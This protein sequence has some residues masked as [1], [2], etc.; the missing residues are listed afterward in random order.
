MSGEGATQVPFQA[1]VEL[2]R[3]FLAN[4]NTLVERIQ[5]LLN[6]QRKPVQYLQDRPFLARQFEDCFFTL[7]AVT[8][9]QSRLRG[10]LEQARSASGLGPRRMPELH[11]DLIAP[12]EMMIRGFYCWRQTRWPGRNGR[13]RYAQALFN[14]Y[15]IRCLELLSI[16]LWDLG[17]GAGD[18]L[19]QLQNVLDELWRGAPD[20]QPV[21]VRDAR[22]LIPL[23]QSPTTEELAA[24]FEVAERVVE[25]LAEGDSVEIQK[26]HV[27][28]IGGHLCSQ[29]R[30]YCIRDDLTVDE[31]SVVR[32]TRTS[33][34]L[35]FALLIQSLVS[36]LEA[37]DSA[38]RSGDGQRRLDLAGAI[39]QGI[40]ADPELFL[41]R[42]DLLGAYSLIEHLF[43]ATDKDGQAAYTPMGQRHIRLL[44]AYGTLINRHSKPLFD[45]CPNFRP[46]DGTCSPYGVI[47]GT[48][49]NLTEHMALKTLQPEAVT[50]FSL[51]DVFTDGDAGGEKLAWVNG[52]RKLPHVDPEMQ[53]RFAYP[54]RFAEEIFDRIEREFR[55]CVSGGEAGDTRLTGR[56]VLLPESGRGPEPSAS[57]IPDLPIRYIVSSDPRIVAAGKAESCDVTSLLHDRH[58]G[59]FALSY[60]TSSGWVAIKKDF[61]TEVLGA[62]HDAKIVGLPLAAAAV[63]RLMC[64]DM[65]IDRVTA[66]PTWGGTPSGSACHRA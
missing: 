55:R 40:S 35:D 5:N 32:R 44:Q 30:H 2:L 36:L 57:G 22:W 65:V 8:E 11:N 49:S 64:P 3:S 17:K 34:A 4:R 41:N 56:L 53:K 26:A 21:I 51:E 61:V 29:I 33:N 13:V 7:P 19:A 18:R 38:R 10:Q 63:L 9:S 42:I 52:W 48:A 20:D 54:Q 15:V 12:A 37:Y 66:R 46:V 27:R 25:T 39:C 23:A 24:Y 6:A 58:E 28:M 47:F 31:E 1:H 16:R 62:G 59:H 60:E 50:R 14:V 45:D 43:I